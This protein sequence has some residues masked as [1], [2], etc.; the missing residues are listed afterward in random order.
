MMI[1]YGKQRR[2]I[3]VSLLLL[4]LASS[5]IKT[6]RCSDI[7]VIAY[8]FSD[9]KS[10]VKLLEKLSSMNIAYRFYDLLDSSA[11]STINRERFLKIITIVNSLGIPIL[12]PDIC[13]SCYLQHDIKWED[14]IF[15][16]DTP[17]LAVFREGELTAISIALVSEGDLARILAAKPSSSIT[18]YTVYGEYRVEDVEAKINL[19]KSLLGEQDSS[20]I[21]LKLLAPIASLAI[22][23]S[24]NPCTFLLYTALLLLALSSIGRSKTF[25]VGLSFI[26]AVFLGY[27]A[28]GLGL[29]IVMPAIP[30]LKYIVGSIG[31]LAGFWN[32]LRGMGREFKPT[33]PR[34][35][36]EFAY[37]FADMAY[38]NPV[39]SFMLGLIVS[40]TLLPCSGG[41]YFV[42]L[43]FITAI[44]ES[45]WIHLFL[46]LYNTI[47]VIPLLS[48]LLLTVISERCI[49]GLAGMRSPGRMKLMQVISGLI[50]ILISIYLLAF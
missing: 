33:T 29:S 37:R 16:F 28:L 43:S 15:A 45:I 5:M 50:L 6:I 12:P 4:F 17:I 34:V 41:P 22:A 31:I 40:L 19:S 13:L 23:D 32:I 44:R 7:Y 24:V 42:A 39:I 48:I 20:I 14:L 11:D 49:R 25:I 3:L 1:D 30:Y 10:S 46:I 27:Y 21:P 47:F 9:H 36:R 18:I 26:T 2:G 35:V 38:L 8:G